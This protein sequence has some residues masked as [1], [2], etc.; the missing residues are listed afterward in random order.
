[1]KSS[2]IEK[3]RS[4]QQTNHSDIGLLI[5]PQISMLPLPIQRYDEPFLPFGKTLIDAT[6]NIVCAYI[7]DLPSYMA[8]G[9]V[10]V[11]ALERTIDYVPQTVITILHGSFGHAGYAHLSDENAFGVDALTVAPG[12]ELAPFTTRSDRG[13]FVLDGNNA[14]YGVFDTAHQEMRYCTDVVTAIRI[15]VTPEGLIYRG[16]LDDFNQ[17]VR[18]AVEQM[19]DA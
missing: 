8:L 1:M 16:R 10:G 11:V 3:L 5:A 15:R 9:A 17:V 19:R 7:F 12:L 13:V 14:E 18:D 6:A 2:F 4:V